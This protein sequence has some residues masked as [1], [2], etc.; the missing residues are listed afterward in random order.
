MADN[1][2]AL[3]LRQVD[4]GEADRMVS[5]LSAERG[6][7]ELRVPQV[8][9]SR[10]RFGGLDLYALA[11]FEL[12]RSRGREVLK[13]AQVIDAWLGIRDSL[14]RLALAAYAAE[15][16]VQAVP[17][18]APSDNAFRLA[19]AAFASLD[20]CVD[21]DHGGQVWARAFELKLL[22]VLGARPSLRACVVCGAGLQDQPLHWSVDQGGVLVG[23]CARGISHTQPASLRVVELLDRC[24]HLPLARQGETRWSSDDEQQARQMMV[25]FI[26]AQVGARDRARRFLDQMLGLPLALLTC[27]LLAG[28]CSPVQAP[29]RVRVQGYL[30]AEPDPADDAVPISGSEVG[31]FSNEGALLAEGSEPFTDYPGFYRFL[32]LPPSSAVH[33]V[34]GAVDDG[35]VA[36]LLSGRSASDDLW[37][38]RG[39]F[40]LWSRDIATGWALEWR[41]AVVGKGGSA[42]PTFDAE[43]AGEGGLLRG[44]L[45]APEDHLGTRLLAVDA[46]GSEREFWYT[47]ADGAPAASLGTS[48]EG[49]FALYGL[50]PGPLQIYVLSE[51]G[52]R[53]EQAFVTLTLEDTVTSLFGFE[54]R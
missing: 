6:R 13:S 53:G 49:G 10:K 14:E 17:E 34:F 31:A 36:T 46:S 9:K 7:V 37:V 26:V 28:G 52:D 38:D 21:D 15:L 54:L 51:Q 35:S 39:A 2:R 32:D 47:D 11:E 33:L 45:T 1:L 40:H 24:L 48:S 25:P 19:Q 41:S 5:L 4:Y 42:A 44:T 29:E 50:A 16:L 23:D 43:L 18:D 3:V 8:R 27:L 20:A 30:F 22:H 12:G